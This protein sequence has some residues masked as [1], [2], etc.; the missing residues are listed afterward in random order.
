MKQLHLNDVPDELMARL[1]E[2]AETSGRSLEQQAIEVLR[3]GLILRE[4]DTDPERRLRERS[5]MLAQ[6]RSR[7]ASGETRPSGDTTAWIRED[8]DSR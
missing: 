7:M 8:R 3:V 2:R 4:I 5:E 6:I 1:R